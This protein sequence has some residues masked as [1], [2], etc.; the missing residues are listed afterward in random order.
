MRALVIVLLLLAATKVGYQ[1]YVVSTAKTE[2]IVTAYRDKGAGA[3]ERASK[4]NLIGTQPAWSKADDVRLVIGKGSLDVGIW[5]LDH[6]LWTARYKNPYLF[7]TLQSRPQ[8]IYCE[9]DIVQGI[10]SVYRM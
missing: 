8:A 4:I 6:A 5:Q 1:Q 3:C 10:A 2:I 7:F 9:F